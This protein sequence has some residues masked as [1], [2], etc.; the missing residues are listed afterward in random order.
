MLA[1]FARSS[2]ISEVIMRSIKKK[3]YKVVI[4]IV[5]TEKSTA[6]RMRPCHAF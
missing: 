6:G 5:F 4:C 1:M 2:F 3:D